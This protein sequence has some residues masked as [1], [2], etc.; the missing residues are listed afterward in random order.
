MKLL[1]VLL[2][3]GSPILVAFMLSVLIGATCKRASALLMI[4]RIVTYIGFLLYFVLCVMGVFVWGNPAKSI[5]LFA[6]LCFMIIFIIVA[7]IAAPKG[8]DIQ[9]DD[10]DYKMTGWDT[11]FPYDIDEYDKTSKN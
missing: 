4:K 7:L 8:K 5:I 1:T 2:T 10:S 6:P 11:M 9:K 3:V